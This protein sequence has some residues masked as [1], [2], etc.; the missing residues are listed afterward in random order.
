VPLAHKDYFKYLGIMF[1]RRMSMIKSSKHA[2]GPFMASNFRARQ[3]VRENSQVNRP[4]VS[5]WLGKAYVLL[6]GAYAGQVWGTEFINDDKV[7]TGDL[8]ARHMSF[9]KGTLGVKRTTTNC[10]S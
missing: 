8:Q 2:A 10:L 5:M 1:Y 6:A 4:Y 7:F 3:F 9:L